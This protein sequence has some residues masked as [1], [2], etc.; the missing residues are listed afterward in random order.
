M[1][2]CKS[3]KFVGREWSHLS[4]INNRFQKDWMFFFGPQK[5]WMPWS[6][7]KQ[8]FHLTYSSS[9]LKATHVKYNSTLICSVSVLLS[10]IFS[11]PPFF[12][13]GKIWWTS[14]VLLLGSSKEK[15]HT[16]KAVNYLSFLYEIL[17]S[18]LLFI[19]TASSKQCKV[20]EWLYRTG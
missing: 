14:L 19:Y 12:T 15:E 11:Y 8:Y 16:S 5:D 3:M 1:K 4:S 10:Y 13:K 20:L 7:E 17:S 2:K 9:T 6:R 18:C